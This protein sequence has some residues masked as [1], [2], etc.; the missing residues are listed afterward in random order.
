MIAVDP[1]SVLTSPERLTGL[2]GG[3]PSFHDAEVLE[4]SLERRD[5]DPDQD[6]YDFP[7][8][9]AK[10]LLV[11]SISVVVMLRFSDINNIELRDFNHCNQITDLLFAIEHRGT[12]TDG[13]P[14]PPYIVVE[15]KCG[16]GISAKFRCFGVQVMDAK[17]HC[18]G[19]A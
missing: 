5:V 11:E 10:F 6:R 16:Y 9:T 15:F 4:I 8:L 3:W 1:T 2:F 14:L 19:S 17:H 12:F 13:T 7:V 18:S